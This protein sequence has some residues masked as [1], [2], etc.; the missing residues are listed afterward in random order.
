MECFSQ[1]IESEC[2]CVIYY[3]PRFHDQ[4]RVCNRIDSNCYNPLRI[5][6]ERGEHSKYKCNCLPACNELDFTGESS[7]AKL[8]N[9][10]IV[11]SNL[12]NFSEQTIK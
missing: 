3:M 4:S 7:A 5:L 1:A 9:D 10:F 11:K 12:L 6:L 2:G 8:K